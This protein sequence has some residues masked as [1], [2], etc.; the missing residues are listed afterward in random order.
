MEIDL[1]NIQD[2][3]KTFQEYKTFIMSLSPDD[4]KAALKQLFLA[5][6][7]IMAQLILSRNCN[8]FMSFVGHDDEVHTLVGL[9]TRKGD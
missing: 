5:Q 6:N 2:P 9:P 1:S 4:A 3:E 7:A 8:I